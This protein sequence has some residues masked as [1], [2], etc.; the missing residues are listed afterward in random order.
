[1]TSQP[2]SESLSASQNAG[3]S[4]TT[5]ERIESLMGFR[6]NKMPWYIT[7]VINDLPAKDDSSPTAEN[8]REGQRSL[9]KL[10]LDERTRM[11]KEIE[12][13]RAAD[14]ALREV[15]SNLSEARYVSF[16]KERFW[17]EYADL[18]SARSVRRT[19]FDFDPFALDFPSLCLHMLRAPPTLFSPIP[20]A[21][22][23][24]WCLDPP[25]Q[26]QL[27][28][29]SSTVTEM[30]SGIKQL[31]S[32]SHPGESIESFAKLDDDAEQVLA[33][34][35]NAYDH[36]S[37]LSELSQREA[38]QLETLRHLSRTSEANQKSEMTINAL[39]LEMESLITKLHRQAYM[40]TPGQRERDLP[41]NPYPFGN[42]GASIRISNEAI[43]TLVNQG[44]DH[45]N[46]DHAALIKKHLKAIR[47]EKSSSY[48]MLGS[49]S[50][51]D[52]FYSSSSR[53]LSAE[54][55]GGSSGSDG[56]M[57]S[58]GHNSS[59]EQ[60]S[61]PSSNNARRPPAPRQTFFDDFQGMAHDSNT[62]TTDG[63][64]MEET[65]PQVPP[66]LT[67]DLRRFH[68][69]G[70]NVATSASSM[71]HTPPSSSGHQQHFDFEWPLEG[72]GVHGRSVSTGI[73]SVGLGSPH[74]ATLHS[75][76]VG[77]GQHV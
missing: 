51:D 67:L 59:H 65:Y 62:Q 9:S 5:T 34:I 55:S 16:A 41:C 26:S 72:V 25:G 58:P 44:F 23:D 76:T 7:G 29:L 48:P 63:N 73:G 45:T 28:G 12:A 69:P 30:L 70:T 1:M 3:T 37:S 27:E 49:Q 54:P 24:S 68:F 77:F 57:N 38:W 18:D 11:L 19:L 46:I 74:T 43:R 64:V 35:T 20:F 32:T 60:P 21:T 15:L 14:R 42:T 10:E 56:T 17:R 40:T 71:M 22:P 61:S 2:P 75:P 13:G 47:N 53:N 36:W 31:L 66:R 8:P 6:L 33:H 50:M 39:R 52:D 4:G